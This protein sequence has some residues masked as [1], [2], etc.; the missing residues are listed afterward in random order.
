MVKKAFVLDAWAMLAYLQKEKGSQRVKEVL[1]AGREG[2]PVIMNSINIG[3]VYYIL[4]RERSALEAD[5]FMEMII[6][7]LDIQVMLNGMD[8]VLAAAKFK[9]G[10]LLSYADAFA[11]AAALKYGAVLLTGD[12]D[13]RQLESV[14]EVEWLG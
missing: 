11:A 6:P 12:P 4:A 9:A 13:F 10:L 3:E 5:L 7:A 8:D 1:S 14:L 2:C